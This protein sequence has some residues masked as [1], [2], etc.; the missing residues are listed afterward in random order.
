MKPIVCNGALRPPIIAVL[1]VVITGLVAM[2]CQESMVVDPS[3]NGA[4][5]TSASSAT[6]HRA[7]HGGAV[8]NFVAPLSGEQE[9]PSVE[10][11]ATGV[12][13][14]QLSKDGTKLR[15]T[16]N[17]A[18]IEDVLMAHIHLGPAGEN[19]PVVVWLYPE[20]GPP[21]QLIEGRFNG[22]LA[23]SQITASDVVGPIESNFADL[24]KAMRTGTAYVNVHTQ[25]NP[26][27]EIRGQID[28]GNGVT[29]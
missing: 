1:G 12:A 11:R 19:G 16:L 3:A 24:L 28:R 9:V 27:G 26:S 14:F 22:T 25:A 10:T 17:V 2:G 20:D 8:K 5:E 15:Y 21:P 23:E 13:K 29:R 6:T 7:D 18:N 4:S